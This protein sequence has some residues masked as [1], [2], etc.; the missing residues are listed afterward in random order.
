[1]AAVTERDPM[2]EI[3]RLRAPGSPY[4]HL[5]DGAPADA[6]QLGWMLA[7]NDIA[8]RALRGQCITSAPGSSDH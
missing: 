8:T 5:L 1:M 6:R 2:A 4:L 3:A 7:G